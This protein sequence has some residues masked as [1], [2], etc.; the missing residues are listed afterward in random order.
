MDIR[1]ISIACAL[2]MSLIIASGCSTY[3]KR[4]EFDTAVDGL[5]STDSD[6]KT[7]LDGMRY[8]FD[9]MTEQLSRKF[10]GYDARIIEFQGRLRVEM[11]AHFAYGGVALRTEDMAAL[12]QFTDV[13]GDYHPNVLVTVEGFTDPAGSVEYNQWLGMERAKAVRNYLIKTGGLN[14]DMVRAVSYGEDPARLV[15]A[16]AWGEAGAVNRRVALVI[17]YIAPGNTAEISGSE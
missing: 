13:I 6:L 4:E 16:G 8:R 15:E 11:T 7:Q 2:L 17:D 1:L 3:V 12:D 9:E 14:A 10:E 5:R